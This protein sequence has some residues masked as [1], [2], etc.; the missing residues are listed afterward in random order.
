MENLKNLPL[1]RIVTIKPE[2]A[3]LLERYNLDYCCRGKQTLAEAFAGNQEKL[4][5]ITHEINLLFDASPGNTN[6]DFN[7]LSL[8]DLI[9]YI[10]N[11]HHRYVIDNFL[12]IESHLS[13]AAGKHGERHSSLIKVLQLFRELGQELMEHMKKEE[14]ILF[15]MITELESSYINKNKSASVRINLAPIQVMEAE[16]E[17]AGRMLDEI[18]KL[19][20]NY[21]PPFDACTTFRLSFDELKRFEEDLH[22]HVHLENNILF[23]KA[24]EMLQLFNREVLN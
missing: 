10:L 24:I 13:K 15:P 8:T 7:K 19:T 1:A 4:N 12:L 3:V 17:H 2:I 20:W 9:I 16:H 23:P 6:I 11:T 5:S 14:E 21:S 18:R 22:M